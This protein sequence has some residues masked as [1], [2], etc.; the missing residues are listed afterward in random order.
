MKNLILAI[1][2]IGLI[3]TTTH[4]RQSGPSADQ[5]S[6]L[7]KSDSFKVG[8]LIKT[9]MAYSLDDNKFNGGRKFDMGPTRL[10]ISGSL[11]AGFSYKLQVDVRQQT[12]L[13][14]AQIGYRFNDQ[15]QLVAG[16]FKPFTS[17]DLDP[18]PGK[19]DFMNRARQVGAMMNIREVGV[20][21]LG[22][23]GGLNYRI[24]VYNGTG[25]SLSND[26]NFMVAFRGGYTA[27]FD[28][29]GKLHLGVNASVNQSQGVSVGNTGL[30]S[31]GDRTTY[32]FYADYRGTR[33]IATA[34]VLQTVF[35]A[36]E[37]AGQQETVLGYFGTFGYKMDKKNVVLVRWDSLEYDL[38]NNSSALVTA[39]WNHYASSVIKVTLNALYQV[40]DGTDNYSGVGIQ[41]QYMF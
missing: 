36:A 20:T 3:S 1:G 17:I 21:L 5:M 34:E 4:A 28:D 37:F 32:G 38:K 15:V 30:T 39:G 26:N 2:L 18:N 33:F 6:A 13:L 10:D 8:V 7:L 23:H 31:V 11:D 22:N 19:I 41:L 24:G 27:A 40:N 16:A 35:D 12:S 9:K 29:G 14:D 25:L